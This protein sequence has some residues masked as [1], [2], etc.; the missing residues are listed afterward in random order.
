[1][2]TRQGTHLEHV[3]LTGFLMNGGGARTQ[4]NL[5]ALKNSCA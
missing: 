3:A 4:K 2:S 1:M 5:L